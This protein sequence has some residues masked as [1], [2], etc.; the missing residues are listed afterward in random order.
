MVGQNSPFGSGFGE[1]YR[2]RLVETPMVRKRRGMRSD[3]YVLERASPRKQERYEV[4]PAAVGLIVLE[5]LLVDDSLAVVIVFQLPPAYLRWI[6]TVLP[7]ALGETDPLSLTVPPR[8]IAV[9]LAIR[10]TENLDFAWAAWVPASIMT[11]VRAR[12]R[13]TRNVFTFRG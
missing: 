7:L 3:D 2:T 10:L 6:D 9:A 4:D 1:S 8:E 12:T 5:Y 13:A 11:T